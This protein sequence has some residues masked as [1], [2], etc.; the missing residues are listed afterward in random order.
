LNVNLRNFAA[1]YRSCLRETSLFTG[2]TS[3]QV[4]SSQAAL[5]LAVPGQNSTRSREAFFKLAKWRRTCWQR[6]YENYFACQLQLKNT[7]TMMLLVKR[8]D[9]NPE[10][11]NLLIHGGYSIHLD[12][13]LHRYLLIPSSSCPTNDCSSTQLLKALYQVPALLHLCRLVIRCRINRCHSGRSILRKVELLPLP[14]RIR[15][16]LTFRDELP[17]L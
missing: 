15:H 13:P 8:K 17:A 7:S 1:P 4:G 3:Y 6:Y 14:H 16:Y 2:A 12:L 9:H 5:S 11:I 10:L